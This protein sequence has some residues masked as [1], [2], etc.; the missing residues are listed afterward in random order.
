[1]LKMY[2]ELKRQINWLRQQV[3]CLFQ[4]IEDLSAGTEQ[5]LDDVVEVNPTTDN[6]IIM[7]SGGEQELVFQRLGTVG[8]QENPIFAM[9][10]II[11]GG[12]NEAKLR[13]I[14]RDDAKY[15]SERAFFEMEGGGTVASL[16]D[17]EGSHYEGFIGVQQEPMF[18]ISST[19]VGG[20]QSSRIE[21][22]AGNN[23][24]TDVF[25]E[26]LGDNILAFTL[27]GGVKQ[28]IFPDSVF[29]PGGIVDAFQETGSTPGTPT[30]DVLKVYNQAGEMG[31]LDS[32]GNFRPFVSPDIKRVLGDSELIRNGF[33]G[34]PTE[35]DISIPLTET[36]VD[37]SASYEAFTRSNILMIVESIDDP[38]NVGRKALRILDLQ[39]ENTEEAM[40]LSGTMEQFS[41]VTGIVQQKAFNFDGS[42]PEILI[43]N[44]DP[45]LPF[46]AMRFVNTQE[47]DLICINLV[48]GLQVATFGNTNVFTNTFVY[49][50]YIDN[51]NTT[52]FR[53]GE[54]TT[55]IIQR[56]L[57][58]KSNIIIEA[59]DNTIYLDDDGWFENSVSLTNIFTVPQADRRFDI[60]ITS[61]SN[62]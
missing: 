29:K 20:N 5:S 55:N 50:E 33:F 44:I 45:A 26:R 58:P 22:G 52:I 9:G 49:S 62:V 30:T 8:D 38:I 6:N 14:A 18:R 24:A 54:Y 27:S 31:Q 17:A 19:D 10:R 21:L 15:T 25:I 23:S 13:F 47:S 11:N 59:G 60:I 35:I 3:K 16:R 32:N 2:K 39:D 51:G 28:I 1:M 43:D 37:V 4:K 53:E 40:S 57:V 61:I 42:T 7:Q 56:F 12:I 46:S 41:N 48:S 36:V 34:G